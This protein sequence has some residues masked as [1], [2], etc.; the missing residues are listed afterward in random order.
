MGQKS[1]NKINIEYKINRKWH[2]N[3]V[4]L[5]DHTKHKLYVSDY[6]TKVTHFCRIL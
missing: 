3:F 1:L 4:L 6:L 5:D 2:I